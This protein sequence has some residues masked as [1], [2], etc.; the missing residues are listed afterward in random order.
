MHLFFKAPINR[1]G[2]KYVKSLWSCIIKI[3]NI[4]R[5]VTVL[6]I[7]ILV[8]ANCPFLQKNALGQ[9]KEKLVGFISINI[10]FVSLEFPQNYEAFLSIHVGTCLSEQYSINLL[11]IY[12]EVVLE[13]SLLLD[14]KAL[15][16]TG[17]VLLMCYVFL[18][19]L[20][21]SYLAITLHVFV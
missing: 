21:W 5:L 12:F 11:K 10:C 4:F 1:N 14:T 3:N 8:L 17:S 7:F 6:L 18:W 15:F 9:I 19:V 13:L 16:V 2:V 20:V